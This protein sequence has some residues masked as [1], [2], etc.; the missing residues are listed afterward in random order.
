MSLK[1]NCAICG[2]EETRQM[3]VRAVCFGCK[4][5]KSRIRYIEYRRKKLAL[6]GK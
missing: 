4:K 2:R 5:E 1:S 3:S 6:T